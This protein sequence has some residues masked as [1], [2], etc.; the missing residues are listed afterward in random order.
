MSGV[1]SY[2]LYIGFTVAA[3][4]DTVASHQGYH[5]QYVE[6]ELYA[7]QANGAQGQM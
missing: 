6:S 5:V 4:S 1:Y 7:S 2:F 3:E